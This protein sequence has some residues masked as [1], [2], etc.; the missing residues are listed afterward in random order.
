MMPLISLDA[1]AGRGKG[2]KRED[3]EV[4]VFTEKENRIWQTVELTVFSR[5]L[6]SCYPLP[7]HN[8]G[9]LYCILR[10]I[11]EITQRLKDQ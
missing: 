9:Q 1:R 2:R 3:V 10:K 7:T 4:N 6:A 11:S 8:P 5:W